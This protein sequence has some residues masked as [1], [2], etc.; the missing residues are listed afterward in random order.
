MLASFLGKPEEAEIDERNGNK[1]PAKKLE[2]R[3][4]IGYTLPIGGRELVDRRK[5]LVHIGPPCPAFDTSLH[6]AD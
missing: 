6:I 1:H 2:G 4:D 5:V 3:N